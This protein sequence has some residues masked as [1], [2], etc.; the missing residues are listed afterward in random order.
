MNINKN[1]GLKAKVE[2]MFHSSIKLLRG[3][4][5]R[6]FFANVNGPILI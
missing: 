5:A 6:P 1:I 3:L 4:F 2:I